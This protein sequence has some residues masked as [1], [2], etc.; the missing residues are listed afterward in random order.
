[1]ALCLLFGA[2]FGNIEAK[3]VTTK[4]KAPKPKTGVVY[5]DKKKTRGEAEDF[6][7]VIS[8]LIFL[9][10]DKKTAAAHE[11]FFIEN[12]SDVPLSAIELEISYYNAAGK[13]IHKR[14]ETIS[15][16]FP[17]GETRMVDIQSWDKQKSFHYAKSIS[18]KT[19]STPYTVRFKVLSYT[20]LQK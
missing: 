9:G 16:E 7:D 3:K 19:G 8:K 14:K 20:P 10:Y 5:K 15:G 1:M 17:A 12:R 6:Q 4:V 18:S 2:F 11:T 13:Q